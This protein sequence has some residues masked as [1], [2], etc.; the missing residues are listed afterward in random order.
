MSISYI[1]FV[2]NSKCVLYFCEQIILKWCIFISELWCVFVLGTTV[3]FLDSMP[4]IFVIRLSFFSRLFMNLL[5]AF[6]E[7]HIY[8][9]KIKILDFFYCKF[10][11]VNF[12]WIL[13][14]FYFIS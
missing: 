7:I 3:K 5:S 11:Y 2:V 12:H 10:T 14:T 4:Q 1:T 13:F 6:F 8:D 9:P